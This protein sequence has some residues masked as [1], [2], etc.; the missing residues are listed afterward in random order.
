VAIED[1]FYAGEAHERKAEA[2]RLKLEK[3][4]NKKGKQAG[5]EN[6]RSS[7]FLRASRK[8]GSRRRHLDSESP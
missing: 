6:I 8:I 2:E 1:G 4:V 5:E 7:M 3:C